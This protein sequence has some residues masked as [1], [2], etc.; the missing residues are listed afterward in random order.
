MPMRSRSSRA[1]CPRGIPLGLVLASAAAATALWAS[2]AAGQ[3]GVPRLEPGAPPLAEQRYLIGR[4][5]YREGNLENAASEFQSAF[6][7]FPQSP[8]LAYNLA[9]TLE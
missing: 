7:I 2:S 6:E 1:T 8:K 5:Q 4:E 3:S 9:R